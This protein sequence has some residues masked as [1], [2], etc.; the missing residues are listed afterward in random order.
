MHKVSVIIPIYGT[1]AYIERCARSLFEQTLDDIEYVF[2]DDCTPDTS[3]DILNRV[4]D[5]Y[6]ERK[7][8][9]K[10]IHHKKNKGLPQ[11]RKTGLSHATGKYIAHC[12]SDD[13][14]DSKMYELMFNKA[15]TEGADIVWCDY[16]SAEESRHTHVSTR[17]QPVLMQGPVWNKLVRRDLYADLIFPIANKGEDG[18]IMTQLSFKSKKR[19]HIP[20]PL[21]YYFI[22]D[23]SICGKIDEVACLNK[24]HQELEN[25]LIKESFLKGQNADKE[26]RH[27]ILRW[28]MLSKKNLLPVIDKQYK[29]W[30][31][32]FRE[33]EMEYLLSPRINFRMKI[34]YLIIL[35]R[36]YKIFPSIVNRWF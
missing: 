30:R 34:A 31:K 28:K 9:V 33:I 21:Y 3:I 26:Y 23:N 19:V 12:D 35:F 8:Q 18:V 11:A 32:T 22:N 25:A 17:I 4:A 29:L 13:W 36:L 2:V 1:E 15:E 6:T 5:E 7:P 20:K 24:F 10:I 14:V 16:Y 27:L